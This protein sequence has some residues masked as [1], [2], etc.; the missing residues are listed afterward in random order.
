M[1]KIATIG[2]VACALAMCLALAACGSNNSSSAASASS[3]ASNS[4]AAASQQAATTNSSSAST[5]SQSASTSAASTSAAAASTSATAASADSKFTGDW[6]MLDGVVNG[7]TYSASD[8]ATANNMGMGVTFSLKPDGT[9][10]LE[11]GGD[12]LDTG[13]WTEADGAITVNGGTFGEFTCKLDSTGVMTMTING[14]D[15]HFSK[16]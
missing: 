13:T 1:K 16:K 12:T 3:A 10:N 9:F 2:A 8:L 11:G 5:A 7:T 4:S 15:S 14:E 6:R